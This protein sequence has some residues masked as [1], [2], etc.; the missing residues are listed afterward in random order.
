MIANGVLLV[1][2]MG[3]P[4]PFI[5]PIRDQLNQGQLLGPEMIATGSMLD[6]A[7]PLIPIISMGLATPEEGRA[8]V[9]AQAKT[10]VNM[11]KVYS[12]LDKDVFLA[13]LDEAKKAG[14]KVV[15]HNPDAIYLDES[16]AAGLASSEHWFGFEKVL[17]RLLGEP[18]E[19]A[20]AG[21]GADD[22]YLRR[23]D[24]VKTTDLEDFYKRLHSSGMT[25]CP[26]VVVFKTGV[27][28]TPVRNGSFPGSEF[29]SPGV[30]EIWKTQWSEQ[31]NLPDYI[32]KNWAK[33]VRG[34]S[35][36]GVPLMVGTDLL[37]PGVVP[38]SSVHEEMEI[39]Q[40]AGIPA[41]EILRA[42]TIVPATFMGLGERLG[43]ITQGKT[44]S[45][46]LLSAN[47][48]KDVANAR[49]IAGV[50]L[51]GTY[52]DRKGLDRLLE[53]AKTS[54]AAQEVRPNP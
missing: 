23:L 53:E 18:V 28:M 47:P 22:K 33:M 32:W 44:A 4:T 3:M 30:R 15:G 8:A 16:A 9:R 1:R 54:V 37:F 7:P 35:K 34:L 42:A 13:I 41:A 43:S 10:G 40:Q 25:V 46:V 6:G 49:S 51:R 12:R 27:D 17:G 31:G 24:E 14:L 29:I 26:T 21:M 36:A 38:G 52:H 2:D 19:L 50:F 20:Y 48:L 45:M 5:L 11:I 39:W